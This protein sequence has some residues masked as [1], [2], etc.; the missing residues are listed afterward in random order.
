M[1]KIAKEDVAGVQ[2]DEELVCAECLTVEELSSV[3]LEKILL[4]GTV[5]EG[6]DLYFCDRCKKQL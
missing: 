2:V 6:E 5:E 1:A 3:E 4:V